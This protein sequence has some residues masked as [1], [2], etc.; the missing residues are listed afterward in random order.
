M[1][2]HCKVLVEVVDL[3]DNYPELTVTSLL[4]T[5]KEEAKM[6]TAIALVSVLDRDG[7]KNGRVKFR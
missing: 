1:A 3:N 5:V 4:D 6:G 2:A 7:G